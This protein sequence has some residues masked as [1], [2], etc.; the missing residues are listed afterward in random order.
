MQTNEPISQFYQ[1]KSELLML[2]ESKRSIPV[3]IFPKRHKEA[4]PN[5]NKPPKN[6]KTIVNNN[7]ELP[8]K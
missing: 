7:N 8:R 5:L 1:S 4:V 3:E 2:E 6:M